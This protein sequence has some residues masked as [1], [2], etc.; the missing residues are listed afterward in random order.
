M[1]NTDL[2]EDTLLNVVIEIESDDERADEEVVDNKSET[3]LQDF[4][5]DSR[6]TNID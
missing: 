2:H 5:W 1:T 6:M 4:T 3:Q